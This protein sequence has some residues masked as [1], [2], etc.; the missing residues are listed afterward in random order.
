MFRVTALSD[1]SKD[2]LK[3]V[4]SKPRHVSTGAWI[5]AQL[6]E[7]DP[8]LY[9]RVA[10]TKY[11]TTYANDRVLYLLAWLRQQTQEDMLEEEGV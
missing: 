6:K 3:S 1:L 9:T 10:G 11:D 7:R 8:E 4:E 5:M 2:L